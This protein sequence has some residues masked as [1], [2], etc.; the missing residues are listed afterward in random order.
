MADQWKKHSRG[1]T[2]LGI[3]FF[4][5][6]ALILAGVL[7]MWKDPDFADAAGTFALIGFIAVALSAFG[8]IYLVLRV[9]KKAF[10]VLCIAVGGSMLTFALYLLIAFR[11][12]AGDL[13]DPRVY[14]YRND[15]DSISSI[16]QVEVA[17]TGRYED[18]CEF[19]VIK[20][21]PRDQ[22]E[23]MISEIARMRDIR[24]FGGRH[25]C[26]QG[27]KMLLIRFSP[28]VDGK[29]LVLIAERY[30]CYGEPEGSRVRLV[31]T[32]DT[33]YGD[34]WDPFAAKYGLD[35]LP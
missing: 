18:E 7:L 20:E 12:T 27:D 11:V 24:P 3:I 6:A 22:W 10:P 4:V 8:T 23:A 2:I 26:Y 21:I 14:D 32:S 13:A 5:F 28:S 30:P 17:K 1:L 25:S 19:R 33:V 15:L 31:P 29:T 9:R 34:D 16:T 35:E